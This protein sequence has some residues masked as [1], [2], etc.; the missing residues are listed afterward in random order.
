[1][2][3]HPGLALSRNLVN[4]FINDDG[5]CNAVALGFKEVKIAGGN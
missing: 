3:N 4:H 2:D 1:M 5:W